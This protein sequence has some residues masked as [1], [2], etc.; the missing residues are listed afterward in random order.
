MGDTIKWESSLE[1]ALKRAKA[2]KRRVLL[3]FFNPG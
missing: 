1:V 2:E 3:D